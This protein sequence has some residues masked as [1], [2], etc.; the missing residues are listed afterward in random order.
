[1]L[2]RSDC[3][4]HLHRSKTLVVQF[5]RG[6]LGLHILHVDQDEIAGL[7]RRLLLHALVIIPRRPLL[8]LQDSL[9]EVFPNP[10]PSLQ[11]LLAGWIGTGRS[12]LYPLSLWVK[13]VICEERQHLSG[14]GGSHI[15]GVLREW[16]EVDPVV[17][18][19]VRIMAEVRFQDLVDTLDRKSV[20]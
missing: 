7:D 12:R 11:Q 19:E 18:L 4:D 14:F 8:G 17:L 6:A 9:L 20:V 5:L 16:K 13:T 1:M 2:F 15:I 3:L 10:L